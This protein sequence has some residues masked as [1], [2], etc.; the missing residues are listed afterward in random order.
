M[1]RRRS[2]RL[3]NLYFPSE[4]VGMR[5]VKAWALGLEVGVCFSPL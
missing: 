1:R 5:Q 4:D 2:R 3:I